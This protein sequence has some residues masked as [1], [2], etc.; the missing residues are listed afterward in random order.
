MKIC[1]ICKKEKSLNEFSFRSIKKNQ[2]K[3]MCKLCEKEYRSL[4]LDEIKKRDKEYYKTHLKERKIYLKLNG[5]KISKKYRESHKEKLKKYNKY[6]KN[7]YSYELELKHKIWRKN[8]PEKSKIIDK[9]IYL[10]R[11]SSASGKLNHN[12]HTA[13]WYSLHSNKKNHPW[14]SLVGYNLNDLKKHLERQ[15]K[16]GMNWN[17]YGKYGWHVDHKIPRAVYN[18]KTSN[19]IDFKKCWSLNNLQPMWAKENLIKKDK[20]LQPFQPSLA[21]ET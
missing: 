12:I 18:F 13:I 9:K 5:Y 16:N 8:N 10:K 15:F 2:H 1:Y 14:E 20:L 7:K 19:D 6:Y 17:N 4:H 11:V 21:I 3:G